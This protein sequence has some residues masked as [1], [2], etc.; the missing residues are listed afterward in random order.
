MNNLMKSFVAILMLAVVGCATPPQ[1]NGLIEREELKVDPEVL[2]SMTVTELF[3]ESVRQPDGT[4]I[5]Q[6][7]FAVEAYS[8]ADLAWKV[9][10]FDAEGMTVKGV[11]EGYRRASVLRDQTRYFTATA[12]HPRVTTYQIHLREP[13]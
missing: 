3:Q 9:N 12:P 7:Q 1:T 11:G 6:V 13:R 2:N 10:W 8:D 5:L 4:S